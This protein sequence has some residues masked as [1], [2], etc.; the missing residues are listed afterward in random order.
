VL[1]GG[2]GTGKSHIAAA[3]GVQAVEHSADQE[4]SGGAE[5]DPRQS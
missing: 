1:I 4:I 5:A 2:P 3:L